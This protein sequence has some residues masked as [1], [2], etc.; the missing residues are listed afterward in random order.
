MSVISAL[1]PHTAKQARAEMTGLDAA[2][3][4]TS[5]PRSIQHASFTTPLA[6]ACG[7]R[8]ACTVAFHQPTGNTDL[9]FAMLMT[10]HHEQALAMAKAEIAQGKSAELKA[11]SHKIIPAQQKEIAQLDNWMAASRA[12]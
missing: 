10:M 2:H 8:S 9:D 12:K 11:M 6:R 5:T 7:S 3:H 1:R 4:R